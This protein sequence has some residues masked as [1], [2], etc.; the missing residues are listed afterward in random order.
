MIAGLLVCLFVAS[1]YALWGSAYDRGKL[2]EQARG[3]RF[4]QAEHDAGVR[5]A[6]KLLRLQG[7]RR[8]GRPNPEQEKRIKSQ[9][10]LI[11]LDKL[12]EEIWDPHISSW[13]ELL[14]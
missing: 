6:Q 8:F 4:E 1:S 3:R 7:E 14:R 5:Q 2:E 9:N 10:N 11:E 13:Q 12:N